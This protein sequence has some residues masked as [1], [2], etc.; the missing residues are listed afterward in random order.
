MEPAVIQQGRY[1]MPQAAGYSI[2]IK[3]ESLEQFSYPNG[4][5]WFGQVRNQV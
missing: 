2:Q 5:E 4:S 3:R 1:I